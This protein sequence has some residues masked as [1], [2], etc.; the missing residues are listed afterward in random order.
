MEVFEVGSSCPCALLP[1]FMWL[2]V[3][4]SPSWFLGA[5]K[6]SVGEALCLPFCVRD[7]HHRV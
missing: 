4:L 7:L 5:D 6:W 1:S 2:C 3:R